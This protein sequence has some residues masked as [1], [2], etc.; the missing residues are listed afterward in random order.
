MQVPYVTKSG[1][2]PETDLEP[3]N[4][5]DRSRCSSSKVLRPLPVPLS[6]I[7]EGQGA[8]GAGAAGD[9]E[10]AGGRGAGTA[11]QTALQAGPGGF[12]V[13]RGAEQQAGEQPGHAECKVGARAGGSADD[14]SW[15]LWWMPKGSAA[16]EGPVS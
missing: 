15:T 7:A 10:A 4:P 9:A 12:A 11:G 5:G 13:R 2:S 8:A 3:L 14:G 1:D 16:C 6:P